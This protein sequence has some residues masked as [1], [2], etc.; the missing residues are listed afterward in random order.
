MIGVVIK[1]SKFYGRAVPQN[2]L[3]TL[4]GL[5]RTEIIATIGKINCLLQPIGYRTND[6]SRETQI[7][8]LKAILLPDEKNAHGEYIRKFEGVK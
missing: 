4:F 3:S 1:Y 5:P 7:E 8:C 2:P 6:D